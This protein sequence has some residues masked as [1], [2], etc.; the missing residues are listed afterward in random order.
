MKPAPR[1]RK[2][3]QETR[4]LDKRKRQTSR[5]WLYRIYI[6]ISHITDCSELLSVL[7]FVWTT[8]DVKV[9]EKELPGERGR[10]CDIMAALRTGGPPANHRATGL[11]PCSVFA[12]CLWVF[13][14]SWHGL[15]CR[16]SLEVLLSYASM[17][18]AETRKSS[19]S[20]VESQ[21]CS[22]TLGRRLSFCFCIYRKG[23][24]CSS[25]GCFSDELK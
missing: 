20:E 4:S 16:E 8:D 1:Q 2:C 10:Y 18:R 23:I 12:C 6:T 3:C 14:S 15:H 13:M 19:R 7:S 24:W 17:G 11:G 22:M 21:L 25:H 5:I 9:S